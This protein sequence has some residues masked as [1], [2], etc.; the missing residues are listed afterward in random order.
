MVVW[1][2]RSQQREE[3]IQA[4]CARVGHLLDCVPQATTAESAICREV[5]SGSL[6][7]S[8]GDLDAARAERKRAQILSA[9]AHAVKLLAPG[10][11]C[12]EFGAGAGHLG[13][14]IASACPRVQV[15]LVEV[16][17]FS[18]DGAR[19]RVSSLGLCNVSVFCG[20]VDEYGATGEHFDCAVGLH[21]CGLLSIMDSL[22]FLF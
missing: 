13:L 12:V 20:T 17:S 15:T 6:D 1:K 7:P 19:A 4:V 21:L 3:A 14:L 10:H 9:A 8:A 16:K 22:Y 5:L 18:C 2:R 11:R